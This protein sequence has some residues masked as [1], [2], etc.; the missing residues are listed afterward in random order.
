V[1][2]FTLQAAAIWMTLLIVVVLAAAALIR[3]PRRSAAAPARNP[4]VSDNDIGRYAAEIVVAADRAAA[5]A[6]RRRTEWERS[7]E[8]V[9][10]AW[11]AYEAA[12]R[13]AR[14]TAAAAAFP[15]L[16]RRRR[17][18]ENADR[19]RYLHRAATAACRRQEISIRQLNE[20][21]AHRGWNARLHPVVQEAALHQAIRD[22]RFAAYQ[23]ATARERQAWETAERAAAA[24][25]SLR[26]EAQDAQVRTRMLSTD[27]QWWAEQWDSTVPIRST[28]DGRHPIAA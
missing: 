24:L 25:R 2:T 12:D 26:A 16:S 4:V 7:I 15:M 1:E 21:L 28:V 13:D 9:D 17:P 19:E 23:A 11:A 6:G 20:V 18:G 22:H 27:E 3:L 5:T 8:D 10:A 14:R